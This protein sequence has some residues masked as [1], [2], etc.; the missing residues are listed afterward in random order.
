[1]AGMRVV[2]VLAL[3][4]A[5]AALVPAAAQAG[6]YDVVSCNAPGADGRNNSLAYAATTFDPQYAGQVG[7]WYEG[8]SSCADGLVARSRTGRVLAGRKGRAL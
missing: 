1:M 8:D 4:A 5:A 2:V 7:G 3:A 6:T